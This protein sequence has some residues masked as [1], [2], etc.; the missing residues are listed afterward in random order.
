MYTVAIHLRSVVTQH[1]ILIQAVCV[2]NSFTV[3]VLRAVGGRGVCR[4]CV[5]AATC[6]IFHVF[7]ISLRFLALPCLAFSRESVHIDHQQ[8]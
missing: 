6:S 3:A 5:A 4:L 7:I 1:E 8:V 2:C